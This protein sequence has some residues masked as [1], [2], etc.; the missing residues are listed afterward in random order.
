MRV[1]EAGLTLVELLVASALLGVVT[2]CC[3]GVLQALLRA[4]QAGTA[5]AEEQQT[6]R[7]A[8]DWMARRLRM[9]EEFREAAQDAVSFQADLTSLP[10]SELHRFCLDRGGGILREQIGADVSSTCNRG[11]PL[12][13]QEGTRGVR[14]LGLAFVYF[15]AENRRLGPLPLGS[16]DLGRIVRIRVEVTLDRGRS[17]RPGPERS[18]V[19]QGEAAVR[20]GR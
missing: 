18:L 20:G 2:V 16:P 12:N 13:A 6:A 10:G 15:D 17:G 9:A 1:R 19:V 14:I 4:W 5:L 8:L 3:A 11:G 7:F